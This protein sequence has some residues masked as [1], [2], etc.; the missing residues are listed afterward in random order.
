MKTIKVFFADF[1]GG[2]SYT[3]NCFIYFLEQAGFSPIIDPNPDLLIFSVF[4]SSHLTYNCKKVFYTGENIR[5]NFDYC[6]FAMTFDFLEDERHV[7]FPF[8]SLTRWHW[9][10]E[11]KD[12]DTYTRIPH[13]IIL[14]EKNDPIE[15]VVNRKFC[16]FLQ[17]NPGC[18]TRNNFFHLLNSYKKVD[19][20]GSLF[21]NTG[22]LVPW[23]WEKLNFIKNYKFVIAFEN[24]ST[25]GYVS[26]KIFEPLV[27]KSVPIYWGSDI[28]NKDF[29]DRSFINCHNFNTFEEVLDRVKELDTND[30]M[31]Y[32]MYKHKPV[33]DKL[34]LYLDYKTFI[35]FFKYK[36]LA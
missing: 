12:S 36:V 17:G 14:Q 19:A 1:W 21:N 35:D 30:E 27:M 2:F 11:W 26:E 31:Y 18:S 8:Y 32:E 28:I 24:S 29:D 15:E 23:N 33:G 9:F 20:A 10:Y 25:P 22:F 5:P 7:R 3:N 6:D 13:D 16:C 4:G 34:S